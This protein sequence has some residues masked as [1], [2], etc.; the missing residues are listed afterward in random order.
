VQFAAQRV[1]R[2]RAPRVR[3]VAMRSLRILQKHYRRAVEDELRYRPASN[4]ANR[5]RMLAVLETIMLQQQHMINLVRSEVSTFQ[6]SM[7]WLTQ[8]QRGLPPVSYVPSEVSSGG[9]SPGSDGH[10]P[11]VR[12]VE[13]SET[14]SPGP[15]PAPTR[16][17][18][19]ATPTPS[20]TPALSDTP[21]PTPAPA[22]GNLF[23]ISSEGS[24]A[25]GSRQGSDD[26][27]EEDGEDE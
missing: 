6:S 7:Q 11:E 24:G 20:A 19:S 9:A 25:T 16:P 13:R 27:E 18:P 22:P 10:L 14:P 2:S 17:A 15:A 5:V 23:L 26:G 21:V 4:T 1:L 3:T 8:T 12:R